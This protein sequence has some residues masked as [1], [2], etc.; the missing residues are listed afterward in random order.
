M[1]D[2]REAILHNTARK[3]F[4]GYTITTG[5]LPDPWVIAERD[6]TKAEVHV[7]KGISLEDFEEEVFYSLK[8]IQNDITMENSPLA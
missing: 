2:P 6:T 3:F 5:L 4:P 7:P 8:R 1:Q